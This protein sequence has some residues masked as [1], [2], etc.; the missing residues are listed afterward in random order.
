MRLPVSDTVSAP[1]LVE[2]P[3]DLEN[4]ERKL[5]DSSRGMRTDWV[6]RYVL[7]PVEEFTTAQ[8][9]ESSVRPPWLIWAALALTLAAAACCFWGWLGAALVL[10]LL[11][12]PLDMIASR[13]ATLRMRPLSA[14]TASRRLL[15]PAAGL[16]HIALA[17]WEM[18]HGHGWGALLAGA[19]TIAFAEAMRIETVW[20]SADP[21]PWLFSR[22]S[23]I[24]AAIPFALAGAWTPYIVGL[25]LYAAASFFIVQHVRHSTLS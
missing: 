4:F 14:R 21:D 5:F 23:A 20:F 25:L 11:T 2:R 16:P 3:A 12:T 8:L 15:A 9:M 19:G 18:T 10:M 24:F 1:I 7:P 17:W 6:S 13:L 22:R